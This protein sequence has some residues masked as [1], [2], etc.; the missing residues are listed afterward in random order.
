MNTG[1]TLRQ[2]RFEDYEQ[3][4]NIERRHGLTATPREEWADLW[5]KNPVFI[6]HPDWPL[7]WVLENDDKRIVGSIGNV[8]L[9]YEFQGSTI[10]TAAGRSWATDQA[11]RSYAPLLM[12]QYFSQK[13]VALFL[14][15][16]VNSQAAQAFSLFGSSR[17]PAGR[18]DSAAFWIT[19]RRAFTEKVLQARRVPFAGLCSYPA[20]AGL[21]LRE[22]LLRK[23]SMVAR[24]VI[25]I[26]HCTGFDHRFE[27]FWQQLRKTRP[28]VLLGNRSRETLEWHFRH[29]LWIF[30][31][32]EGSALIAYA[33]F[34]RK[35]YPQMELRRARLID[36][37]SLGHPEILGNILSE[38]LR[39]CTKCE[40]EVLEHIG[41]GIASRSVIDGAAP[42]RRKLPAWSSY[43][44]ARDQSLQ[45]ALANPAA[46]DPS[47]FDGDA[48][49]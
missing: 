17:V 19:R 27:V 16:T 12:D 9:Y 4:A 43:Y 37:Q 49:L 32:T 7:G 46:W 36:F 22:K 34:Q 42:Y 24:S 18:W 13:N 8:P 33:I 30:T 41:S 28:G 31:Y 48:S 6:A 38:A 5:V 23:G 40:L 45:E 11:Y 35:D 3:I 39:E 1:P 21:M 29:R 44:K 14:N 15:T 2:T 20:A 25:G 47:S 10:L 26:E